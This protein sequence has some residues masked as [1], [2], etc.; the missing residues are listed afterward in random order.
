MEESTFFKY[1]NQEIENKLLNK[2]LDLNRF[3][4]AIK[5]KVNGDNISFRKYKTAIKFE[6]IGIKKQI[7]L[8]MP[9]FVLKR[10]ICFKNY[11][12]GIGLGNSV[13]K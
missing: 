4:M 2:F 6:N 12:T 9:G 10:L 5:S 8:Y 3:S 11:F 1:K 13:F 7:L